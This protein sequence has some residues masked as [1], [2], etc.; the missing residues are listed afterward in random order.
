MK[1]IWVSILFSLMIFSMTACGI[2]GN[3]SD[4]SVRKERDKKDKDKKDSDKKDKKDKDKKDKDKKDKQKKDSDDESDKEDE[5]QTLADVY[6]NTDVND[7]ITFGT[8]N[9]EPIEWMVLDK[10]GDN[11]LLLTKYAVEPM[12]Y[13]AGD[14]ANDQ[15]EY[16]DIRAWLNNDF[17]NIAFTDEER[18]CINTTHLKNDENPYSNG[19]NKK[20]TPGKDT[21]DKLYLLSYSEFCTYFTFTTIEKAEDNWDKLYGN[22]QYTI[23][24]HGYTRDGLCEATEYVIDKGAYWCTFTDDMKWEERGYSEEVL[25]KTFVSW[26]LRTGGQKGMVM[27]IDSNGLV[28][29]GGSM[30]EKWEHYCVRPA[31]WVNFNGA[32]N[33]QSEN[34]DSNDDSGKNSN[35]TYD[36][37]DDNGYYIGYIYNEFIATDSNL[38]K[39]N[40]P[41]LTFNND[42]TCEMFL[43]L[44]DGF[45]TV[46]GTFT[47]SNKEN[48]MDDLYLY[49]TL[50]DNLGFLPDEATVLFSDT[51]DYC[52]FLDDGFG[53]MSYSDKY[54]FTTLDNY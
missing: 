28:M 48:E 34:Q 30:V 10:D 25:G 32:E 40:A 14:D 26:W 1:K 41:R 50:D 37:Y 45:Q 43:N 36:D 44:G 42:G 29:P 16:S 19:N 13:Y 27:T 35:V 22:I 23:I 2:D 17:I 51:V 31:M 9:N 4:E 54:I 18:D 46:Y 53:I 7:V 52:E 6:A 11:Y 21:D 3:D 47:V 20:A 15:W 8:Y 12:T 39:S 49:I 38:D 24:D 5:K 33:F